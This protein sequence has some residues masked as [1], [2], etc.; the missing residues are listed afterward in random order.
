MSTLKYLFIAIIIS[1]MSAGVYGH[2]SIVSHFDPSKSQELSGV[3][4]E[5]NYRSPHSFFFLDVE[6]ESGEIENW[7]VELGSVVHL[8]RMGVNQDTFSVGDTLKIAIWP[9]RE[10]NKRF[11]YGTS[12]IDAQ[13]Q[14]Y[15]N[16]PEDEIQHSDPTVTGVEAVFGRWL[17]PLPFEQDLPGLSLTEAGLLAEKNY[18]PSLSPATICEPLTIP[19]LQI[20]PYMTDIRMEDGMITFVHEA[21]G[22]TRSIPLDSP[23]VPVDE[24]G[25]MGTASAYIDG[26]EL[27]IESSNYPVSSWGLGGA[28][29][30]K[31]SKRVDYPSSPLK[32]VVE[33]YSVTDDGETLLLAFTLD[34]P[35]YLSEP[36]N[37]TIRVQRVADT[38]PMFPFECDVSSASRF[39]N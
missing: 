32:K 8:R 25:W 18:K 26:D 39:S 28:A 11:V 12:F 35:V 33:R 29:Q 10:P 27:V 30:V 20:S 23:Q 31:G 14:R 4:T 37:G 19:D 13:D 6:N 21:Y 15:G 24:T 3:L 2:H 7:E 17:S 16:Y 9:N 36:Y 34:D 38:E 22:I 5:I 1:S